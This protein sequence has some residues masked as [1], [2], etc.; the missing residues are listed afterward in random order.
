MT[1]LARKILAIISIITIII[2]FD[3]FILEPWCILLTVTNLDIFDSRIT[4]G[5]VIKIV[6]LSDLHVNRY[7]LKEDRIIST[8]QNINPNIIV[9]TGDYIQSVRDIEPLEKFL[10]KIRENIGNIPIIAILG[11]WDFSSDALDSLKNIFDKH[12]LILL[13]NTFINI[14]VKNLNI[15]FL[16]FNSIQN[17]YNLDIN[18]LDKLPME[19]IIIVLIHEP[20]LS[21]I[22]I[23]KRKDIKLILAGH[24]HGG[25]IKIF[26]KYVFL[27]EGCEMYPEGL[28]RINNTTIYTSR[29]LGT[30]IFPIR[31]MSPPEIVVINLKNK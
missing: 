1:P 31:F 28:Y 22:I 16:G 24:C 9:M 15:T 4:A 26:N 5:E 21:N 18:V 17:N 11:N 19:N 13:N 30:S 27:P 25:Q 2:A 14:K 29:G 3:A 8:I 20:I 12:D 10:Q 23:E 7:G 6:Q